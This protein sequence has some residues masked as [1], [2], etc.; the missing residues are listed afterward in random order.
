M[1][2]TDIT[3]DERW[4]A[5]TERLAGEAT[6]GPWLAQTGG[7]YRDG[8]Y[9]VD[10]HFV[11][12]DADDVAIASDCRTPDGEISAANAA[13]IARVDPAAVTAW[14]RETRRAWAREAELAGLLDEAR[15]NLEPVWQLALKWNVSPQ[16]MEPFAKFLNRLDAALRADAPARPARG[17]ACFI[18]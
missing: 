17:V 9:H 11:M 6:A 4:L 18:R 14:A 1:N 2:D 8:Q 5:E 3:I 16:T 7:S 12:R 15:A 13:H 10:E